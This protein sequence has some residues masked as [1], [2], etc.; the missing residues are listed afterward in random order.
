LFDWIGIIVAVA[1]LL[2]IFYYFFYSD[3]VRSLNKFWEIVDKI[4][5]SLETIKE[6]ITHGGED[7][8]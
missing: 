4:E 2:G 6:K 8:R 7:R 5:D 1:F 3:Y